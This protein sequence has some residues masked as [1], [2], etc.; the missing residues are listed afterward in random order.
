MTASEWKLVKN[1]RLY[2]KQELL[3]GTAQEK[4]GKK[5]NPAFPE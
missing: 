1:V 5:L 3:Q 4:T 2:W